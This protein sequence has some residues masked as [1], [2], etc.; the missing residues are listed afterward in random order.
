M[1]AQRRHRP[2]AANKIGTF[3][4]G[5][6]KRDSLDDVKRPLEGH[7]GSAWVQPMVDV[8]PGA[9]LEGDDVADRRR[10]GKDVAPCLR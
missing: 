8:E 3:P 9:Y 6:A 7:P 2:S 10:H 4:D 5:G 1:S